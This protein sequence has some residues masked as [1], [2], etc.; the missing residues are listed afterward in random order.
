M[1]RNY[2]TLEIT[3]WH[4]PD[5]RRLSHDAQR[6]YFYLRSSPHSSA[7]HAYVLPLSYIEHDT[8]L[9]VE[10]ITK[11]FRELALKPFA[12][13]DAETNVV[14]LPGIQ[15]TTGNKLPN[16]NVAKYVSGQLL[17]LPDCQLK[18]HAIAELL[19]LK[20]FDKTVESIVGSWRLE[21]GQPNLP[22]TLPHNEP[23]LGL[24]TPDQPA[25]PEASP[26]RGKPEA[27]RLPP[28]WVAPAEYRDYASQK[29]V[30]NERIDQIQVRFVRYWTGA[31]A[32][33]PAKKDWF[34]TWQNWID[35]ETERAGTNGGGN[36][37]GNGA[38]RAAEPQGQIDWA[39]REKMYQEK[40]IW[41]SGWDE[42]PDEPGYKHKRAK[43]PPP[44][45]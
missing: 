22:L 32:K 11:A 19:A 6:L 2:G 30:S 31:D 5:A 14:F 43:V 26:K 40:G 23:Q 3:F 8:G 33:D 7:A 4:D 36:G 20:Q 12:L 21:P 35:K 41:L 34:R 13:R 37:N 25:K 16:S 28:D 42:K 29:G 24:G 17:A 15:G 10:R 1:A 27:S 45:A 38:A 9:S 18:G 44:P 39:H